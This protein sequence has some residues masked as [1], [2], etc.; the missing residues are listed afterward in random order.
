M[1]I[2][3]AGFYDRSD[4]AIT[5]L[6][7]DQEPNAAHDG[8]IPNVRESTLDEQLD[9]I[10]RGEQVGQTLFVPMLVLVEWQTLQE[11]LVQR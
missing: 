2:A 6:H 7:S 8:Y 10:G 1:K 9:N 11:E 4:E 3:V 5:I